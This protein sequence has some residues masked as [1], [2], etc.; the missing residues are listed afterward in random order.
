MLY[1]MLGIE[2]FRAGSQILFQPKSELIQQMT[3]VAT[4]PY[5]RLL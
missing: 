5:Q 2:S 1:Q 4:E 3:G